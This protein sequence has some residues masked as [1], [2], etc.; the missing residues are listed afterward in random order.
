LGKGG[1][2]L[3][4]TGSGPEFSL[5]KG[6]GT[7]LTVSTDGQRVDFVVTRAAQATKYEV[8]GR[9]VRGGIKADLGR[10]GRVDVEFEPSGPPDPVEPFPFCTGRPDTITHGTFVGAI[11]FV[12][13]G[14]FAHFH[15]KRVPGTVSRPGRLRCHIP[16]GGRHPHPMPEGEEEDEKEVSLSAT[17]A[18]HRLQFVALTSR[19]TLKPIILFAAFSRETA[20]RI[21][22]T[23]FAL[24]LSRRP[25]GFSFDE[26]LATATVQPPAP[27]HGSAIFQRGTAG[28][29]PSWS[30]TLRVAFLDREMALTGAGFTA[31]LS[32]PRSIG[33]GGEFSGSFFRVP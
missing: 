28:S 25:A 12:G 31:S 14:H 30:G 29:P 13:R 23:R 8:R 21:R 18:D 6:G 24:L 9:V 5:G 4:S 15:A 20:D 27:F 10:A 16:G 26:A 19:G 7:E 22:I 3:P 2:V 1:F 33:G 17:S 11:D 32:V